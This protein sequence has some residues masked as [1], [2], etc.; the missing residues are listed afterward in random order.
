M[1]RILT[2]ISALALLSLS[3]CEQKEDPIKGEL[4]A[5]ELGS[6]LN[7]KMLPGNG[8]F[9]VSGSIRKVGPGKTVNVSVAETGKS[10]SVAIDRVTPLFRY[11]V[12]GLTAGTYHVSLNVQDE[13]GKKTET[14]TYEAI[15]FDE[16]CKNDFEAR[17]VTSSDF[18]EDTYTM[19]LSFSDTP[20]SSFKIVYSNARGETVEK[21]LA[22]DVNE[23][24]L[25]DWQDGCTLYTVSVVS[26][27]PEAIDELELAPVAFS[28]P[29]TPDKVVD[30]N[31]STFRTVQLPSDAAFGQYGGGPEQMWKGESNGFHSNGGVGVPCH[32]SFDLGVS[33]KIAE[34]S[35]W[36]RSNF[37]GNTP[38]RWQ[39]WGHP[40]ITEAGKTIT[41]FDVA[42]GSDFE[43]ASEAAGWVL[44]T[45]YTISS[46]S[47]VLS[48]STVE[49]T[50]E[51]PVQYIRFRDVESWRDPY[52]N[53]YRIAFKVWKKSIVYV[54]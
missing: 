4:P 48:S 25:S 26:P 39:I 23:Y 43:A 49:I 38:K 37:S 30:L 1:K 14:E 6:L 32:T 5:E 44:L 46:E 16:S 28:I 36:Y 8:R 52:C 47:E 3:A 53:V 13:S 31:Y 22:S 51:T 40:S 15:V 12:G 10:E 27:Y 33:A 17:T 54:D 2:I 20:V 50:S 19:H 35:L 21:N 11:E 34:V 29:A 42:E 7:V 18:N 24:T 9:M 45:D 41:D